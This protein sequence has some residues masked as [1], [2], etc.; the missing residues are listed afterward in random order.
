MERG[1]FDSPV[2]RIVN[3]GLPD[4]STCPWWGG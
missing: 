2:V 1:I 3:T 4:F